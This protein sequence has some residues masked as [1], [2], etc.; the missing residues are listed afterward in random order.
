MTSN[1][2]PPT[3]APFP[4]PQ[5][6]IALLIVSALLFL[7]NLDIPGLTDRDEGSNAEAAREMLESGHWISPTLNYEPRFAKPAFAYWLIA[8][9]Y[10]VFGVNE[11][12]ARFPSALFGI[13]LILLQYLFVTRLAGAS[14]GLSAALMLLLNIEI[15]TIG[16]LVLTDSVLMF[17]TTL[18][19]YSFW[20]GL[21]GHGRERHLI[22]LFYVSMAVALLTKGPV[23]LIIPLL[24]VIPYLTFTREWSRF[25]ERGSP[26]AGSA[27]LVALGAPWYMAMFVIHGSTYAESAQANTIGR[28]LSVLEGHGGTILFYVPVLFFGFF[29]WSGLLPAALYQALRQTFEVRGARGE[30]GGEDGSEV[31]DPRL[32]ADDKERCEVRRSRSEGDEGDGPGMQTENGPRST[33]NRERT[34]ENGLP[35][36]RLEVFA[37]VWVVG[38]FLFFTLSATRLPHYI[39]PLYPG[40]A[41]LAALYWRRCLPPSGTPGARWSWR[42]FMVLGYT[43]GIALAASPAIY[44]HFIQEIVRAFPFGR[45]IGPG[46]GPV[47][48]GLVLVMGTAI[49]GHLGTSDRRRAAA[50]WVAGATIGMVMLIVIALILPRF[51]R[52]F[53]APPQQLAYVAGLN[54]GSGDRLILYG[55][56][57]PS[58]IFYARRPVTMVGLNESER[59]PAL[60]ESSALTMVILQSQHG[61]DLPPPLSDYPI[62]LKRFGWELRS[63]RP[64]VQKAE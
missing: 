51:D 23:G 19:V 41:I 42:L 28:F 25:K 62:L 7:L 26:L 29:P 45:E 5:H 4:L 34:G 38:L 39:A 20:L 54:L 49:A 36:A 43:M 10:R 64:M 58:L 3:P 46:L 1:P 59:L 63:N 22:W 6:L 8:S 18:A 55:L 33:D 56:A 12:A 61:S 35:L 11:F 14:I 52:Y 2:S 57:K 50:F 17:S 30:A 9:S 24:G 13:T 37:A 27:L 47:A 15:I 21:Y 44:E 60:V 48:A 32:G 53:I 31:R 40:A 16:R